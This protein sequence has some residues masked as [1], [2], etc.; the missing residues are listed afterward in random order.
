MHRI[1]LEPTLS[2]AGP[3]PRLGAAQKTALDQGLTP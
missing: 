1:I 2:L 3:V